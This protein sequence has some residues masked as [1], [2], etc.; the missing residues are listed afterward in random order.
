MMSSDKYPFSGRAGEKMQSRGECARD[1]IL[2]DSYP[3]IRKIL[4]VS[5]EAIPERCEINSG[6]LVGEGV[7]VCKVVFCD[8]LGAI[9]CAQFR[10][11]YKVTCPAEKS[12]GEQDLVYLPVVE[13]V[14]A[15]AV[16]PRKVG[17]RATVNMRA[18]LW[19]SVDVS[20]VMP[21]EFS[22]EDAMSVERREQD[23]GYMCVRLYSDTGREISEDIELDRNSPAIGDIVFVDASIDIG[24]VSAAGTSLDLKGSATLNILYNDENGSAA[25]RQVELP[26]AQSIEVDEPEE[27]GSYLAKAYIDKISALAAENS[28]GQQKVIELDLAYSIYVLSIFPCER[29]LTSDA[30]STLYETENVMSDVRYSTVL[31]MFRYDDTGAMECECEDGCSPVCVFADARVEKNDEGVYELVVSADAIT[32][33]EGGT[34]AVH[35]LEERTALPVQECSEL[36]SDANV[37]SVSMHV[38]HDRL[39]V[40]YS[41]CVRALCWNNEDA[42][43][44]SAMKLTDASERDPLS[45]LTVCYLAPEETLWDAAKRYHVSEG[46]IMAAN[47][48]SSRDEDRRVLLIPRRRSADYSKII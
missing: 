4:H 22:G 32:R 31:P 46:A 40:N 14:S 25:F 2:P 24:E 17:I 12:G 33:S 41:V 39:K 47:M 27:G 45:P 11:D 10:T 16:N 44:V 29:A 9:N 35:R 19:N 6:K 23:V 15:K 8:D 18:G 36:I 34:Y 30:Y 28:F 7:L 42:R 38:E 5:A 20:P 26:F 13:S 1:F 21:D 37:R 3:D 43:F 48:M